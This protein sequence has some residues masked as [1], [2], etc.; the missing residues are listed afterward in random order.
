M[1]TLPAMRPGVVPM[2]KRNNLK[3]RGFDLSTYDRKYKSW[4]VRCSQCEAVVING[5]ACH[6]QGCPNHKNKEG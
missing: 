3:A 6:E 4:R 5:I 1:R 2:S